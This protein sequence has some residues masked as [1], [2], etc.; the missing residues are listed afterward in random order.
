M[1]YRKLWKIF[2]CVLPV[3]LWSSCKK[4]K[5]NKIEPTEEFVRYVNSDTLS[6]DLV[7]L[8]IV[9]TADGGYLILG[10]SPSPDFLYHK[11]YILKVDQ[12]GKYNWDAY[13]N[14]QYL[15]P[16][17]DIMVKNGEYYLMCM[18]QLTGTYLVKINEST[19]GADLVHYF[20]SISLPLAASAT[21]DGGYLILN[22]SLGDNYT[23]FT[24]VGADFKTVWQKIFYFSDP[25]FTESVDRHVKREIPPL[26]F[27]TGT[28]AENGV[29]TAYYFNGYNNNL[30]CQFANPDNG[31]ITGF[32]V[33]EGDRAYASIRTLIPLGKS[34]FALSYYDRSSIDYLNPKDT[35]DIF[36]STPTAVTG[37]LGKTYP[38]IETNSRIVS[39]K[40]TLSGRD[41]IVY[42]ANTKNKG[43]ALYAYDVST[44]DYLGSKIFSL[45]TPCEMGG[46]VPAAD[47]GLMVMAKTYIDSRFPRVCLFKMSAED[48][49]KLIGM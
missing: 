41:V 36:S 47:G 37:I 33:L 49:K 29:A 46:F 30:S 38:E 22:C 8:D 44:G 14:T 10:S 7:P 21:P 5:E 18:D 35:L 11:T 19:H 2:L 39:R 27:F 43:V 23:A 26:P 40:Y 3:F 24:K 16:V 1:I 4:H 34:T 6:G 48:V 31:K 9:A 15:N 42:A 13:L 20:T 32:T 17:S 28:V 12:E 45:E 25:S